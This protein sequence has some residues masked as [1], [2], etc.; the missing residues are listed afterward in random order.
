MEVRHLT[1][2]EEAAGFYFRQSC[3]YITNDGNRSCLKPADAPNRNLEDSPSSQAV[4]LYPRQHFHSR[5]VTVR[6]TTL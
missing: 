3:A 5:D 6:Y 1:H 2:S 4:P